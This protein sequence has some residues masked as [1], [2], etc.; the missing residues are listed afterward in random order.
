LTPSE[1]HA[2]ACAYRAHFEASVTSAGRTI[3]HN[4]LVGGVPKSAHLFNLAEDVIYDHVPPQDER[5][6]IARRL[7]L[8]V[9]FEGDHDHL[10]PLD[11]RAG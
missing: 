8:K 9:I 11:W 1:F 10:Q 4:Q 5:L 3:A 2:A 6:E 7:G